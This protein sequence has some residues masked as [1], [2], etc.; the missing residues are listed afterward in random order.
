[1][2]RVWSILI[3][4]SGTWSS[5][6]TILRGIWLHPTSF[7][8]AR[9]RWFRWFWALL[10]T[11]EIELSS[12]ELFPFV[13]VCASPDFFL[14]FTFVVCEIGFVIGITHFGEGFLYQAFLR[15]GTI[16]LWTRHVD[17]GFICFLKDGG[18]ILD[19]DP[20]LSVPIFLPTAKSLIFIHFGDFFQLKTA[21]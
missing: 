3:S 14:S 11:V 9:V 21:W 5:F 10:W 19:R 2:N 8:S 18:L 1:V 17:I 6:V 13:K 15:S 20:L 16:L 4:Q 12:L 7:L